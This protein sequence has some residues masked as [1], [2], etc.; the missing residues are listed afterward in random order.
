MEVIL[1]NSEEEMPKKLQEI[2]CEEWNI[3]DKMDWDT[4]NYVPTDHPQKS[5]F[6]TY[7]T[8]NSHRQDYLSKA[9]AKREIQVLSDKRKANENKWT[10]TDDYAKELKDAEAEEKMW[11]DEEAME[12]LKSKVNYSNTIIVQ[13]PPTEYQPFK[14]QSV[15]QKAAK[16]RERN[17]KAYQKNKAEI[18]ETYEAAGNIEC[19]FCGGEHKDNPRGLAGHLL[20]NRHQIHKFYMKAATALTTYGEKTITFEQAKAHIDNVVKKSE[21][22]LERKLSPQ[23]IKTKYKN[24]YAQY[25]S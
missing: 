3:L 4:W 9:S 19:S 12:A 7:V 1:Y 23:A 17:R 16:R 6:N 2:R 18:K 22:R 24:L 11:A 15:E 25:S 20:T 13:A 8:W 14:K 21:E 5:M 10:T